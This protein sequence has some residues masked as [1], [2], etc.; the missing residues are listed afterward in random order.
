MTEDYRQAA[1][2]HY[3]DADFLAGDERYDNAGHLI[4]FAAECAIKSVFFTDVSVTNELKFHLPHLAHI[5]LKKI[6]SRN[7]SQDPLRNL[8]KATSSGFFDDWQVS[9]RYRADGHVCRDTY[10]KWKGLAER[11]LGAAKIRISRP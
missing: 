1:L 10:A 9:S 6:S 8:L 2:R 11:A 3:R 4:G 5:A 7:P